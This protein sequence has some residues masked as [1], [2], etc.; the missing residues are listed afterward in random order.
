M[1][2]LQA[3]GA[4]PDHHLGTEFLRLR[5][6]A[7]GQ[8]LSGDTGWKAKIIFDLRTR[9][10]LSSRRFGFNHER[11]QA[12]RGSLNR[13]RQAGRPGANDNNV[14]HQGVI[15][16]RIETQAIRQLLRS[17]VAEDGAASVANDD[18]NL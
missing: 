16:V 4:M 13:G 18:W 12:F 10:C 11:I 1:S 14:T 9:S 6:R 7:T 3:S 5:D 15:D 2:A 8:L 17:G